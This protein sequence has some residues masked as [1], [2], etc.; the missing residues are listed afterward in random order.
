[1]PRGV[2]LHRPAITP[3]RHRQLAPRLSAMADELRGLMREVEPCLADPVRD[4]LR[5]QA[6]FVRS[7]RSA[8][9]WQFRTDHPHA[10]DAAV[11]YPAG[12]RP[13]AMAPEPLETRAG[14]SVAN[15]ASP[16]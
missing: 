10:Y 1:M 8:L 5:P 7:L 4:E 6:G 2:P 3:D 9:D 14:S 13:K 16:T 12:R 11:Y 15:G